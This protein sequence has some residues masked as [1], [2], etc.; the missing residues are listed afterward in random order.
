MADEPPDHL[1]EDVERWQREEDDDQAYADRFAAI[2]AIATAVMALVAVLIY[3]FNS[4][5]G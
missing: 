5:P 3:L 4:A 2:V 1:L